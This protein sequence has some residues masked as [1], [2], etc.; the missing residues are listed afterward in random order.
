M[1]DVLLGLLYSQVL[2]ALP[3]V[4]A[5]IVGLAALL[6]TNPTASP[7]QA[8]QALVNSATGAGVILASMLL[9]W[10]GFLFATFWAATRKGDRDWRDLLKWHFVARRDIPIAIVTVI[11]L[12]AFFVGVQWLLTAAGVDTD[13]LG[14]TSMVT[15]HTGIALVL[16]TAAAVIGAPLVEELFF[17]GLF[18]S[19]ATRNYGK[20]V[21]VIATSLVFGLM[22]A[23]PTLAGTVYTVSAT[24]VIGAVF[25]T[26]VLR[27]QRL[28]TSIACH[29]L[30]NATSLALVFAVS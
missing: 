6:R 3:A 8:E 4:A 13:T 30:F 11:A 23:Q 22:H 5:L 18:L 26:L 20:I 29:V 27:T 25:A 15:G 1:G 9:S 28:G 21:A 16:L 24:A 19:V 10:S 7:A 2:G 12:Q 14:N 17:R